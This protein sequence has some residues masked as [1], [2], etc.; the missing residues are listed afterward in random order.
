MAIHTDKVEYLGT[1]RDGSVAYLHRIFKN[2][3][4]LG[5]FPVRTQVWSGPI[6]V[7]EEGQYGMRKRENRADW[8]H[9]FM[10]EKPADER[11]LTLFQAMGHELV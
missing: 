1:R 11:M 10:G 7:T 8:N 4:L 6:I 5:L 2:Q 9:R 3:K